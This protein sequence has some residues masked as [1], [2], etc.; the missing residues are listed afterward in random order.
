MVTK[1]ELSEE[2]NEKLGV[3]LE[4]EKMKKDDLE[5]F[6]EMIENGSMMESMAKHYLKEKGEEK[7]EEK[8]DEWHPG[9]IAMRLM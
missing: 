3:D 2:I 5:S 8:V 4:W 7:L 9:K 6:L 1:S